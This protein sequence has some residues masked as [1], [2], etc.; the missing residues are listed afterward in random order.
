MLNAI[1]KRS[2]SIL[3]KSLLGLLILSFVVWG[4]GDY[5]GGRVANQP[6]VE[7][8][9]IGI[10]PQQF[11]YEYRQDINLFE[12]RLGTRLTPDQARAFGIVQGTLSRVINETLYD[13]GSDSLGM[14]VSDDAIATN[15][16]A[17][18]LFQDESGRFNRARFEQVLAASGLTEQGYVQEL[19]RTMT[20]MHLAG[21]VDAGITVP[22]TLVDSIYRHLRETRVAETIKIRDSDMV[23]EREPTEEELV[24]F[25]AAHPDSFTAPE[26]RKVTYISLQ[27]AE[28][29]DEV[30]VSDEELADL[31]DQRRDE[32]DLPERREVRQIVTES[33]ET[34]ESAR[35]QILEGRD[36]LEVAQEVANMDAETTDLGEVTRDRL[37]SELADAAFALSVNGVSEPVE[38][39]LGWHILRVES[40]LP[41][42]Q[43]TLEDVRDILTEEIAAEKSIDALFELSNR[44]EDTLGGGATLEE[45][46]SQTNLPIRVIDAI[47]QSGRDPQ[48]LTVSDLPPGDRFPR[49]LF[50]TPETEESLLTEAGPEGYFILRVD[51]ITPSALRPLESV[52]QDVAEAWKAE[53]RAEAAKAAAEGI[54][55]RVASG[56]ELSSI[57]AERGSDAVTTAPFDRA[58]SGGDHGLPPGVVQDLFEAKQ[59]DALTGRT[60]DGYVVARLVEIRPATPGTDPDGMTAVERQLSSSIRGDLQ[61]QFSLALRDRFPVSVNEALLQELF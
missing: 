35:Q 43:Q 14:V 57:A 44:L 53:R 20:R 1:R 8:G 39:P 32:F 36:F 60:G 56:T 13:L 61:A 37:L 2:A 58:G 30:N 24:S 34:A 6:V 59:R 51:E 26:Y 15:I 18:S 5:V 27:A 12:S 23:L 16:R 10:G 33:R 25:H 41:G 45:G 7:V 21:S 40:I 48:G 50:D 49:T 17:D 42:R 11:S 52:R 29:V 31:Y 9:D 4:V 3:I 38:S 28:L 22:R 47:D 54:V 19:R 46:A 55:E